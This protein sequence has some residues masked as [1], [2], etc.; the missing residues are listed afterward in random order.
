[1]KNLN[2][3]LSVIALS[4]MAVFGGVAASGVQAFAAPKEVVV[5]QEVKDEDEVKLQSMINE[6]QYGNIYKVI[7]SSKNRNAI[8]DKAEAKHRGSKFFQKR[9]VS[10]NQHNPKRSLDRLL[11]NRY[12]AVVVK[13]NGKYFLIE[14]I[15]GM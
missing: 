5:E 1:M 3:K 10:L 7:E 4:G 9:S 14:G 15:Y 6:L 13:F 8:L 2:R 12:D 11:R